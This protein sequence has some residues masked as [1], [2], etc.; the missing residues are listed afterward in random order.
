MT[1]RPRVKVLLVLAPGP[2]WPDGSAEHR[3]TLVAMLD[4]QGHL[5]PR[6]W[7]EDPE[8]WPAERTWPGEPLREGDVQYD[9]D[10][11]WS[12]RFFG[13]PLQ[14]P[15]APL[16]N[17]IRGEALMRPGEYVTIA[18]PDGQEY[19]YRIVGVEAERQGAAQA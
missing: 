7:Q 18:E 4:S 12:L 6:G 16:H 9:P 8:P 5:D 1:E 11:G 15:D 14:A 13:A 10:S 19:A 2:S 17:V 3:Y